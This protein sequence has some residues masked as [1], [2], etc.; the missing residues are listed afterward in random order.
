V[1]PGYFAAWRGKA[2]A[3]LAGT[4]VD[5]WYQAIATA[6]LYLACVDTSH[7]E[8]RACATQAQDKVDWVRIS[9]GHRTTPVVAGAGGLAARGGGRFGVL[10]GDEGSEGSGDDHGDSEAGGG[11]KSKKKKRRKRNT[12]RAS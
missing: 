8:I 6:N 9:A 7:K 10:L 3:L 12:K 2:L 5:D 11:K 1:H 4:Q